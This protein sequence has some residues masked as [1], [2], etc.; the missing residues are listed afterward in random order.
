MKQTNPK[1][2]ADNQPE[3]KFDMDKLGNFWWRME[4]LYFV[5]DE[6]GN[7]IPF[8]LRWA[9]KFFLKNLWFLNIILKARQLGFTTV[10]CIYFLD[11]VLFQKNKSAGIIAHTQEDAENIFRNKILFA[12]DN[13][14]E[15]LKFS[16]GV[17]MSNAKQLKFSNGGSIRVATSMRSDTLQFLLITELGTLALKYPEKA[18]EV[19]SGSLNT[20]HKGQMLIIESTA[21]GNGGK[22]FD[23]CMMALKL[24]RAKVEP[25][26]MDYK[27]FFFPWFLN[28]EYELSNT[29]VIVPQVMTEYFD[30]IELTAENENGVRGVSIPIEKRRWYVKKM[31]TQGESMKSEFPSTPE[32]AFEA[33]VE[34][35]IYGKEMDRA[36]SDK[37]IRF[38]PHDSKLLVDTY[39]DLGVGDYMSIWF[40]QRWGQ[41]IRVIDFYENSG[42]GLTH[43][44]AM[45]QSKR[46][47]L[48]Y[49]YGKHYAPHD[50]EVREMT[51]GKTR[52]EISR[53]PGIGI[54]FEVGAKIGISEGIEAT[55]R[56]FGRFY[57]DEARCSEG[58]KHIDGYR[59]DW[60]D[61]LGVW[62]SEPRHDEH[63]HAAD[64][65]RT[66]GV[67]W[68]D[69]YMPSYDEKIRA[70]QDREFG[71]TDYDRHGLFNDI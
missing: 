48:E 22:F 70:E 17:D 40:V 62:K 14:P 13:L 52:L 3:I 30:K 31:E 25:T 64:A 46:D 23:L 58:L 27:F 37:R 21:K 1:L 12:W 63:S 38:V 2:R 53:E 45:L 7:K 57:F 54:N 65:L 47:Q 35:A 19:I 67:A 9:Q 6:A 4:N 20:V 68:L 34:G 50:I 33:S 51:T 24:F 10:I 36:R 42:E 11:Q 49:K 28:P 61:K 59:K 39:W 55:K 66:L 16:L 60:D 15:E 44:A 32:E 8:K 43:Y 26:I 5:K 41:E 18:K 29:G 71:R 56:I 69:V